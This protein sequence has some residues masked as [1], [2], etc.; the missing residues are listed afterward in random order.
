ME[1]VCEMCV[2]GMYD[3]NGMCLECGFD[4]SYEGGFQD[5]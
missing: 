4:E 1:G 3:E 2:D 5:W